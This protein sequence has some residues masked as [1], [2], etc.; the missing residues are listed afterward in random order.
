MS[1]DHCLIYPRAAG[2]FSSVR[3]LQRYSER[4]ESKMKKFLAGRDVYTMLKPRK[5]RLTRRWT[6]SKDIAHLY[7]IDLEDVSNLFPFNDGI[8]Y[9][10]TTQ[11]VRIR[12][13]LQSTNG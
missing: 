1:C 2:S 6:Y 12:Y 11:A 13:T 7:Q 9:F 10:F 5:I 4:F 3:N 8:R